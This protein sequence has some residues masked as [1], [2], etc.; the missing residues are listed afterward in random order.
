MPLTQSEMREKTEATQ[1][2]GYI[3]KYDQCQNIS[4]LLKANKSPSS[5]Q[6]EV[7]MTKL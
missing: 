3:S 5:I 7:H 6:R 1:L 2:E 4:E